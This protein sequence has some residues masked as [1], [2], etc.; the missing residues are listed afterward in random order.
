MHAPLRGEADASVTG[1]LLWHVLDD[2]QKDQMRV[3]GT[4]EEAP[5]FLLMAHPRV[6]PQD[7]EK[8][9]KL[10]LDFHRVPGNETYFSTNGF[11]KFQPVDDKSMKRLD[12]YTQ[13]FLK[14]AGP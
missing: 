8:I 11:E 10:L 6:A 13:I 3:I 7:I 12:L 9:K 1:K 2:A 14:P 5:G 4:T